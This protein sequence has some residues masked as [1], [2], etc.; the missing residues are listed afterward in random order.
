VVVSER[1]GEEDT[2]IHR[3]VKRTCDLELL[4]VVDLL[5]EGVSVTFCW[6]ETRVSPGQH[7]GESQ[8]AK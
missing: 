6:R 3:C 2:R 1:E 7:E 4:L 8:A 5:K